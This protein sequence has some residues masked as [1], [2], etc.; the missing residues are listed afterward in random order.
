[1]IESFRKLPIETL[2]EFRKTGVSKYIPED[3]QRYII[4]IDRAIELIRFDGNVS[5]VAG[6]LITEFPLDNLN[7]STARSRIYDAINLFHVNST[8]KNIAWD[9]YYADKM[10]DLAKLSIAADDITEARRCYERAHAFRTNRNENDYDPDKFSPKEQIISPDVTVKRLG[11]TEQN[12]NSM[13]QKAQKFIHE[14]PIEAKEKMRLLNEASL[15]V[16]LP[17][18]TDY[19]DISD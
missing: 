3:L 13:W 1:M 12:L 9:N 10:E 4:H 14:I 16:D 7:S 17:I 6:K 11:I 19:E 2:K 18:D 8:V 15:N 5:R